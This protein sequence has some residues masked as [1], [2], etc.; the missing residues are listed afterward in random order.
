MNRHLFRFLFHEIILTAI[1]AL[2]A[3]I[4]FNQFPDYYFKAFPLLIFIFFVLTFFVH[5]YLVKSEADKKKFPT[6]FMLVTIIKLF[7]FLL[8]VIIYKYTSGE[9]IFPFVLTFFL[10]YIIYQVFEVQSF[11]SFLKNPGE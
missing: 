8:V 2:L 6:R 3:V 1:I 5:L 11:L 9:K 7:L 10:L 4:F